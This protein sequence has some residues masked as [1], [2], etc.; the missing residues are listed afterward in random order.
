MTRQA[1]LRFFLRHM[2]LY[3][4]RLSYSLQGSLVLIHAQIRMGAF[5]INRQMWQRLYRFALPKR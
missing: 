5:E 3:A 2:R 1:A 4:R